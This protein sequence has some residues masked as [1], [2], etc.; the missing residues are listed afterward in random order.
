MCREFY[1]IIFERLIEL[2]VEE[3]VC[4]CLLEMLCIIIEKI[5]VYLK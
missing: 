5:F 2:D 1:R 4:N 3:F